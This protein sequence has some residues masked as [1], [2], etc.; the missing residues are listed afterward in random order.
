[1]DHLGARNI[2]CT[3][4]HSIKHV[5]I[6]FLGK[7]VVSFQN[8][9]FVEHFEGGSLTKIPSFWGVGDLG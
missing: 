4:L 9:I 1:M 8:L 3:C 6:P 2:L 5:S 7:L